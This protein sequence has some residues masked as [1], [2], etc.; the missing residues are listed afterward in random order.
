MEKPWVVCS[1]VNITKKDHI[2]SSAIIK[3]QGGISTPATLATPAMPTTQTTPT[4]P[5]TPATPAAMPTTRIT[6]SSNATT[7]IVKNVPLPA[8]TTP[9][10]KCLKNKI[11]K[12]IKPFQIQEEIKRI[13]NNYPLQLPTTSIY[14]K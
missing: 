14:Y 6:P 1:E 7:P 9:I 8:T 3:Y 4:M 13:N 5:A 11:K 10:I 12:V 2:M